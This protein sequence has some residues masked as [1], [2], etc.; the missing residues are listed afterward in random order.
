[1][2]LKD[3]G[4]NISLHKDTIA[5]DRIN[6]IALLHK[7]LKKKNVLTC[8]RSAFPLIKVFYIPLWKIIDQRYNNNLRRPLPAKAQHTLQIKTLTDWWILTVMNINNRKIDEDGEV[9]VG[10][11]N[12]INEKE[13][14]M[15][16][17]CEGELNAILNDYYWN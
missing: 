4:K 16:D 14:N 7:L 13:D 11:A 6:L 2:I 15:E 17:D 8:M 9:G 12:A 3:F 10:D 5:S 1:M